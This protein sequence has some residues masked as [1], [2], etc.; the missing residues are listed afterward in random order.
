MPR[1]LALLR[2]QNRTLLPAIEAIQLC[3]RAASSAILQSLALCIHAAECH[4]LELDTRQKW[5]IAGDSEEEK[6]RTGERQM[7]RKPEDSCQSH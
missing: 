4:E 5:R 3:C 2:L 1:R 7:N 6:A